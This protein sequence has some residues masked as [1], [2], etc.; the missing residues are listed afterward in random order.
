MGTCNLCD[1]HPDDE[2]MLEHLR[3]MHP[4]EYGDGPDRWPDGG[5]VIIDTTA[6]TP[7]DLE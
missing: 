5:L 4:N 1:E 3:V 7:A 2:E 6:E